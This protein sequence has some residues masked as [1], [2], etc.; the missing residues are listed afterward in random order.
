MSNAASAWA[1]EIQTGSPTR[2]LVLLALADRHN[3]DTGICCP[4]VARLAQD[5][6]LSEN[7]VRKALRELAERGLVVKEARQR[8]NGSSRSNSY[9]LKMETLH[10][11]E[12]APAPQNPLEPEVEPEDKDLANA[13]RPRKPNVVWDCLLEAGFSEPQTSSEKSD[14]GKT[15]R[16]LRAVIPA[17][18]TSEQIVKAIRA[19]RAAWERT[20]P[21]AAF[22]HHVLRNKWGE[23][24]QLAKLADS[25]CIA[26]P[27]RMTP[28]DF[29]EWRR[30]APAETVREYQ[31]RFD[32]DDHGESLEDGF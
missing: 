1:L 20:Y 32:V 31:H 18:A 17:D 13:S 30:T 15:V 6:E 2:K 5:T 9:V 21:D 16:E 14:F 27:D 19:R 11:V 23:L 29:R 10:V 12:G 22:T 3:R 28:E 25:G 7:G 8:G 26:T 24:A 4:S